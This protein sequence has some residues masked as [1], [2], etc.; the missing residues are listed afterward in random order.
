MAIDDDGDDD[1]HDACPPMRAL[2][3]LKMECVFE[4]C[5]H[6]GDR[7]MAEFDPF[8][9]VT[10]MFAIHYFFNKEETLA[11]FLKNV[12]GSMKDGEGTNFHRHLASSSE[13]ASGCGLWSMAAMLRHGGNGGFHVALLLSCERARAPWV[14]RPPPICPGVVHPSLQR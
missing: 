1:N 3:G 12:S 7:D 14:V 13:P 6:L 11:Q 2:A 8:D 5:E 9:V 4:Q 10:C